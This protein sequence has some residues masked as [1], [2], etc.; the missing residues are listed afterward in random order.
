[1]KK[2]IAILAV[3]AIVAGS[4]FAAATIKVQSKV[5]T[6]AVDPAFVLRASLNGEDTY[7]VAIAEEGE[8]ATITAAKVGKSIKEEAIK[9]YFQIQQSIKGGKADQIVKLEVGATKMVQV[10]D[11][12]S[13]KADGYE[14]SAATIGDKTVNNGLGVTVALN[15]AGQYVVSYSGKADANTVLGQFTVTWAQDEN[16]V[17]GLYQASVSLNIVTE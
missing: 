7:S 1:M 8:E 17:D 2:V 12:G 13:E 11:D 15:D 3:L 16:A 10:N 14:S 4:V 5:G 6:P 9:V